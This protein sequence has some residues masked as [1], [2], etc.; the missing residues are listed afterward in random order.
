MFPNDPQAFVSVALMAIG[1]FSSVATIT[2]NKSD[3]KV[4]QGILD[5]IN[6]LAMNFGKAENHPGG[7]DHP[8]RK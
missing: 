5:F 6:A 7:G 8:D 2:P 4:A 3:N 1:L